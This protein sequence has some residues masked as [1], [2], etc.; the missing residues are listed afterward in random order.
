MIQIPDELQDT[1]H[2]DFCYK[3]LSVGPVKVYPNRKTKCG[4]CSEDND[5]VVSKY[6]L[7]ADHCLFKCVNRFDGCRQLLTPNQVLDHETTCKSNSIVCPVCPKIK[8]TPTYMLIKHFEKHHR[9]YLL[10][11]PSFIVDTTEPNIIIY[12]YRAND[13]LFFIEFKSTSVGTISLNTF[14]LGKQEV[15]ERTKQKFTILYGANLEKTDTT[16]KICAAYGCENSKG[17]LL[18]KPNANK[19]L[20]TFILNLEVSKSIL[21]MIKIC[22]CKKKIGIPRNISLAWG[23]RQDHP[24]FSVS[25]SATSVLMKK[26][27][28]EFY[29]IFV[30]CTFCSIPSMREPIYLELKPLKYFALCRVCS[31]YYKKV[32]PNIPL[33]SQA[34]LFS[35]SLQNYITYSCIWKPWGCPE[36]HN[37]KEILTHEKTCSHQP[38]RLCPVPFCTRTGKLKDLRKHFLVAHQKDH[39]CLYPRFSLLL[40]TEIPQKWYIWAFYDF[41]SLKVFFNSSNSHYEIRVIPRDSEENTLLQPTVLFL[42]NVNLQHLLW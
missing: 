8:E 19:V 12:L 31:Q 34:E 7:I 25:Q 41:I 27:N 32:S 2:C 22:K 3:L 9:D 23:F 26:S 18:E 17:F 6:G 33:K 39:I 40:T 15:A 11:S 30:C 38:S 16:T 13:Q 28:N 10:K 36:S 29:E 21:P 42:P 20:V 5:R 35:V 24:E 1:L 4:R 14:Y 37:P